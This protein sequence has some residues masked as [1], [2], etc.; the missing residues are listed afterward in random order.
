MTTATPEPLLAPPAAPPRASSMPSPQP[1]SGN[2]AAAATTRLREDLIH[3]EPLL[4]CLVEICRLHGQAAS[5]A[6]LSAGLPL[7]SHALSLDLAERAAARAGMSSKLQ[8][9]PLKRIDAAALPAIVVLKDNRA[10]VLLG[11]DAAH[12]QARVLLPETGQGSITL[13]L[14]DLEQRYAGVT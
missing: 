7:Q 5:R 14:A 11:F 6:S 9:L 10:C 12:S 2:A 8:R 4:D 1:S 13:A 3:P